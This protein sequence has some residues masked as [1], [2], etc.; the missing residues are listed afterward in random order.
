MSS[1][2]MKRL[3]ERRRAAS[4]RLAEMSAEERAALEED[5]RP[6]F[7][8]MQAEHGPGGT[9]VISRSEDASE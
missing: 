1:E 6:L 2:E 7:D 8:R 4:E 9:R 3:K 5:R